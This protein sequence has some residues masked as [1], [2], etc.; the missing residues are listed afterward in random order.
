MPYEIKPSFRYP[1]LCDFVLRMTARAGFRW[2]PPSLDPIDACPYALH[3]NAV[4]VNYLRRHVRHSGRRYFVI[5]RD[6]TRNRKATKLRSE[7][8]A[9]LT[10]E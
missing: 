8:V 1:S 2:S 4:T 7:V 6:L 9:A 3:D 5:C 10:V